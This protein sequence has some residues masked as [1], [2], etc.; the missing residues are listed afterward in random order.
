M[1]R[2]RGF[3]GESLG[4]RAQAPSVAG[5][6]EEGFSQLALD[7]FAIQFSHNPALRRLCDAQSISPGRIHQWQ[8]I[9]AVPTSAFKELDVTSLPPAARV[10]AFHS[11]GTTEQRPSRHYHDPESLALYEASL[12]SWFQRHLVPRSPERQGEASSAARFNLMV[13]SL[14]PNTREAP[15]SSLVHMFETVRSAFGSSESA[16]VGRLEQGG[17][18][19]IDFAGV[20]RRLDA[21][22]RA[23]SPVILLGSA[24]NFVHLLDQMDSIGSLL[25]SGSRVLETGGYKGR[26]RVM[27]KCELHQLIT[28]RLGVSSSQIVTEYGMSELSSQAYDGVAGSPEAADPARRIFRFPPWARA[29]VVSPESGREVAEGETGL[30]RIFDLANVRSALAVQ[31]EDLAI[32]RGTGFELVGRAALAEPRGC[33]LMAG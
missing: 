32:R 11:S 13:L 23:G 14:T 27:S 16:F 12:L 4:S 25:P 28:G 33:S 9:P 8:D 20:R 31:T 19:G 5:G 15:N 1:A 30:L 22:E 10:V 26:S 2:L 7:L 17:A 3:M 24:F 18:W 6:L 21:A 29:R